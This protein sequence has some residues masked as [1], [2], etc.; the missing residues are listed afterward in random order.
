MK[1][2][3]S[4]D[5]TNTTC[6]NCGT[7]LKTSDNYCSECG[8]Q[9]RSL[10]VGFW[11]L[12]KEFLSN[13]FNFDTKLG[14]TI[15]ALLLHPGTLTKD[16][17]S[18]K[19]AQFVR[20][21]QMYFFVSFVFFLLL[22][23]TPDEPLIG[24]PSNMNTIELKTDSLLEIQVTDQASVLHMG[25]LFRNIDPKD[26]D[27][28]DSLLTELGVIPD[29]IS[30]EL[31]IRALRIINPEER[32]QMMAELHNNLSIAM[33]FLMLLFAALLWISVYRTNPFFFDSIIFSIH[34]HTV[35]FVLLTAD[36]LIGIVYSNEA[37]T[38]L[39]YVLLVVYLMASLKKVYNLTWLRSFSRMIL[40]SL[41][42]LFSFSLVWL[43]VLAFS[44][45]VF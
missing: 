6:P 22:G 8:Q 25:D 27:S 44:F 45:M 13:N 33:F 28:V 17:N 15:S 16:F 3:P 10:Q 2:N 4:S 32:K 40:L 1:D 37:I 43:V 21:L 5:S 42:Y 26:M 7:E 36:I 9:N 18:G 23:L 29:G 11:S 12:T 24:D 34:F 30:R 35:V 31:C 39:I 38:T 14:R 19:R 20:P 41:T